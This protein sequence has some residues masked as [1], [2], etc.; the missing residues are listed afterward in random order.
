MGSTVLLSRS[1]PPGELPPP[2]LGVCFGRD[3]VIEEVVRLAENPTSLALIGPGGIGKT[4]IALAVLHHDRIKKRYGD[5]RWFIR[6]DQ[7]PASRTHFL[8]RISKVTGAGVKN[9]EDLTPLRPFLSS[10]EMIILLDN[11]ES[12]L[13]PQGTNAQEIYTIVMELSQFRNI[14]LCFTSRISIVPPACELLDIPTLSMEAAHNT[15][16]RIY[17][18]SRQSDLVNRI[19][20]QLDFHP[21]SITLLA[22]VAYH[23]K[24]DAGRLAR[25]WKRRRTGVLHTQH[26]ESLAKTIELSLASP[27][28]QGLGPSACDL[29]GVIAFFPRGINED[30]LNW[31]FPALP[32]RMDI[33]DN[34]C[35]LS[36]TYRIDGFIRMLAPLRDYFYPKDPSSSPL[37][38][39]IKEIYFSRLSVDPCPGKC[40][41]Y[42]SQWVASEDVN[43]EHLFDVFT[44]IDDD[45]KRVWDACAQFMTHLYWQ[46][47]RLVILGPKIE[48]LSDDHPSKPLCLVQLS[49]L[50]NAVGNNVEYKRL[51]IHALKLWRE[52]R[53]DFRA[54]DSLRYLSDAN[55]LL[56]LREEGMRQARESLE[57]Y[58]QLD[59]VWGE[60]HALQLL[61][62]LLHENK[63]L[64]AAEQAISQAIDLLL[65]GKEPIVV[66][67]C[68]RTL[69]DIYFSKGE[70]KKAISHFE[71]SLKLASSFNWYDEQFWNHHSMAQLSFKQ[72]R[73]DDAQTH[74]NH[75]KSHAV[76][77]AYLLGHAIQLQADLWY[78]QQRFREAESEALQA[79][80]VFE[81]FGAMEDLDAC[82]VMLQAIGEAMSRQAA[83]HKLGSNGGFLRTIFLPTPIN[84]PFS[85][86]GAG[87]CPP[88]QSSTKN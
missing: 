45:S 33:I 56:G 73:P 28:F 61:G 3:D 82:R 27:M 24:W 17:K 38:L 74:A 55:R 34:L 64:D 19:L 69:G 37:L 46:K 42:K 40:G 58:K 13:D 62:R 47:R 35:I 15:F 32:N 29:L 22:T 70:M 14:C 11:A 25:E 20:Q 5:N 72:G 75:A 1:T 8:N 83:S 54:A 48:G 86:Q 21:L 59:S 80:E 63:E 4:S 44:S 79:A 10:R 2:P 41:F 16:Y 60:A 87:C 65:G 9:A 78:K 51:L 53:N 23:N 71:M 12:I 6:C 66:C 50:F 85:A 68:Y 18:G 7:F 57:I 26:N 52:Q 76:D 30:N 84:S 36:L 31:L 81:R 39:A 43:V 77:D 49:W 67:R 88:G